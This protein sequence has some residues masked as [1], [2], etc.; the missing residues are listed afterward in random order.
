MS[1]NRY[2]L[3]ATFR[4]PEDAVICGAET[5]VSALQDVVQR[6]ERFESIAPSQR[7]RF[8]RAGENA[9]RRRAATGISNATPSAH[10]SFCAHSQNAFG[11]NLGLQARKTRISWPRAWW[12]AGLPGGGEGHSCSNEMLRSRGPAG[13]PGKPIGLTRKSQGFFR[14]GHS[15]HD[16]RQ[17]LRARASE[18][19]RADCGEFHAASVVRS[20][21]PWQRRTPTAISL[22]GRDHSDLARTTRDLPCERARFRRGEPPRVLRRLQTLRDWSLGKPGTVHGDDGHGRGEKLEQWPSCSMR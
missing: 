8:R 18:L 21:P 9:A 3:L 10:R 20:P 17:R 4:L 1:C 13:R 14:F 15:G 16:P 5:N 6:T 2:I 12:A 19:K 22:R 7:E 11:G